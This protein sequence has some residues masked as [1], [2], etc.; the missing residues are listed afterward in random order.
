M[1]F[2][3]FYS[4]LYAAIIGIHFESFRKG[5]ESLGASPLLLVYQSALEEYLSSKLLIVRRAHQASALRVSQVQLL[6]CAVQ[7]VLLAESLCQ[8]QMPLCPRWIGRHCPL[9]E[10]GRP[11]H[12][13]SLHIGCSKCNIN[14]GRRVTR[15]YSRFKL[16]DRVILSL[17]ISVGK[18]Q[19]I[20]SH[21]ERRVGR[22]RLLVQFN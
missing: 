5:L 17:E 15:F 16:T 12:I 8:L 6:Q 11:V 13:A 21:E 9:K 1:R 4:F 7:L 19:V 14:L 3:G 2:S 20:M 18:S 22:Q 10:V